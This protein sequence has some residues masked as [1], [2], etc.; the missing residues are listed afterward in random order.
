MLMPA[1]VLVLV[2]LGSIAVD[3]A[4]VFLAQRE[5]V[6]AAAAAANDAATSAIVDRSFY[7]NGGAIVLDQTRAT[8]VAATSIAASQPQGLTLQ[9]APVVNV[10]GAAVCVEL[11]ARVH[12]IFAHAIPGVAHDT[13]VSARASA[14]AVGGAAVPQANVCP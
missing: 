13:T 6:N 11:T 14:T 10:A 2:I 12:H 9:G 5:L 7:E 8:Q 1:A 4:V 3:S